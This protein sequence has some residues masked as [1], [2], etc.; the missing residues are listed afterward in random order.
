MKRFLILTILL[1]VF[2]AGCGQSGR[3][4]LP[5]KSTKSQPAKTVVQNDKVR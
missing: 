1:S 5:K 2:L 3:L 4:Y